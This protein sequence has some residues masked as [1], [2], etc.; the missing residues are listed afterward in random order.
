MILCKHV[1]KLAHLTVYTVTGPCL[2]ASS[3]R[4]RNCMWGRGDHCGPTARQVGVA[5]TPGLAPAAEGGGGGGW[6]G[7][8]RRFLCFLVVTGFS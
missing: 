1:N 5:Y 7:G 4:C 2:H 6:D 8:L 3:H